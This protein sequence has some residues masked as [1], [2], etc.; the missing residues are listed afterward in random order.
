M[1]RFII[2]AF[3]LVICACATSGYDQSRQIA[4]DAEMYRVKLAY[5]NKQI[6][7]VQRDT[8]YLAAT[9]QYFPGDAISIGCFQRQIYISQDYVS[10]KL[11][12]SK[13]DDAY[14]N[15]TRSCNLAWEENQSILAQQVAEEDRL[16]RA[17]A[18]S[19]GLSGIGKAA[20]TS[21]G[22]SIT[23]PSTICNAYGGTMYCYPPY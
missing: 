14:S 3:S 21:W 13:A 7:E 2:A 8:A 15:L 1:K 19:A 10:G 23:P 22:Q 12:K 9:K 6:N 16:R 4:Y 11:S 5:E 20:A 18:I 17:V